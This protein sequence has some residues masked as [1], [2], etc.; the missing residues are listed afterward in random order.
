[1]FADPEHV[2]FDL[3][4]D[5]LLLDKSRELVNLRALEVKNIAPPER[6]N[7]RSPFSPRQKKESAQEAQEVVEFSAGDKAR[8]FIAISEEYY[9]FT[10]LQHR[11]ARK[12]LEVSVES[13]YPKP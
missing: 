7:V 5:L 4:R 12:P 11:G 1:M 3:S 2:R 6:R 8:H 13:T 9:P 10:N